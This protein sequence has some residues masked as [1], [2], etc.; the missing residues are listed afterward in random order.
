[1]RRRSPTK[2]ALRKK[3]TLKTPANF[4]GDVEDFIISEYTK[5][6]TEHL[7]VRGTAP[8]G[9]GSTGFARVLGPHRFNAA[10]GELHGCTAIVV[11]SKSAIW[12]AHFWEIPWF[13]ALARDF[14]KPPIVQDIVTFRRQVIGQMQYGKPD[15]D[16]LRKHTLLGG[17]PSAAE[18]PQW[19]I[20]TPRIIII[21]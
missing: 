10:M 21:Y 2:R 14:D 18:E 7:N 19:L 1:M 17:E 6:W 13:R 9:I 20:V 3:R 16:D 4:G 15:I 12:M 8:L 11:V 5:P